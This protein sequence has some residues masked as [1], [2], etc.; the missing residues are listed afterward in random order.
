MSHQL[1]VVDDTLVWDAWL[2][3]YKVPALSVALELDIF[4]SLDAQPD[5]PEGLALRRDFDARGLRAL[6]PMLM[7]LGFLV[8]RERR[9]QLTEAGTQYMLKGSPFSWAALF[10]RVGPTIA[11]HKLLLE[12][13]NKERERAV[14]NRPADG[15]ESG[16]VDMEMAREVT[17][18]MHAHSMPAAQGMIRTC[19]FSG[20]RKVLDVGGGSGCF[21]IALASLRPDIYCS[22]MEL[23]TIC[24][25]A[26]HYIDDAGASGQVDTVTVDMF[27]KPWPAGFDAHF[28]SNVF[29]DWSVDTCIELAKKSYAALAPGGC[30][31]L[32]EMLLDDSG[33]APAPAVAFS[34]LMAMGTLGQQFTL[35][36]LREILETAGFSKI[37]SQHSYG[38]YSLVRAEK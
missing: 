1:P 7:Q 13:I 30:I 29:H 16:H 17:A 35:A 10:K 14:K 6:L 27:R 19:D 5:T 28:F 2:A 36:Q 23:P 12:T 31:L 24:E 32:H 4:E 26:Q 34:L 38:Y 9:F 8:Q 3:L 20:I 22:I 21:S 37:S 18:F 15:W 25:L 33:T 11:A